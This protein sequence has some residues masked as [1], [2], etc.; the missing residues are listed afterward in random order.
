MLLSS[1]ERQLLALARVALLDA[2]V[3]ILDE[4]TASLDPAT[5]AQVNAALDAVMVGRTVVLIA[6]RLSSL[7]RVDR[8]AVIANGRIAE[9]GSHEELIARRGA[10]AALHSD[11]LRSGERA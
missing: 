10:Y 11:W 5:E 2:D 8:V 9:M 6:H 4:A 7:E 1:G 3:F